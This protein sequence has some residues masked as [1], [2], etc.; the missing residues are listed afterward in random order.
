[1]ETELWS[2]ALHVRRQAL[3]LGDDLRIVWLT[4]ARHLKCD[5]SAAA[6]QA[7]G[8]PV[9]VAVLRGSSL[10]VKGVPGPTGDLA[11]LLFQCL[12]QHTH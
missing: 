1:V 9:A 5:L 8:F 10:T 12:L 3:A 6:G 11:A 2:Q 4:Q 7:P